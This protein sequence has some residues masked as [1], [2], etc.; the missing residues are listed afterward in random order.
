MQAG[1]GLSLAWFPAIQPSLSK[2]GSNG[3]CLATKIF[4]DVM[5]V[6]SFSQRTNAEALFASKAAGVPNRETTC[7]LKS[8]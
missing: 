3:I 4:S 1:D 6:K 7:S 5:K 2:S 8:A